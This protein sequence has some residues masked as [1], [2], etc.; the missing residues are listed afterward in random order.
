MHCQRGRV[1]Q[2]FESLAA[3]MQEEEGDDGKGGEND[4]EAAVLDVDPDAD[5]EEVKRALGERDD[6]EA[7]EE[8]IVL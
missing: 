5:E 7:A 1:L 6:D 2:R 4:K 8:E 3:R